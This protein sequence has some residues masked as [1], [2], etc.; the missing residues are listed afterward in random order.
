MKAKLYLLGLIVAFTVTSAYAQSKKSMLLIGTWTVE[1][2]KPAFPASFSDKQ[3]A[4]GAKI[5]ADD[6][7]DFKKTG[8][9]F[10][11]EGKLIVEK[12][13]FYWTINDAGTQVIVKNDKS[14]IKATI[15]ELS[16]HRLVFSRKDEGMIV[17]S[18]LTK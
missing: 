3:K 10:T 5:V 8:F 17:T 2:M 13:T 1:S 6:E 7:N 11:K 4:K 15:I 18:T 9:V 16:A 14:E 12:K